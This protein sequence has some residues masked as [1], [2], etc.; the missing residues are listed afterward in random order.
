MRPP[1]PV[2]VALGRM[3]YLSSGRG[4]QTNHIRGHA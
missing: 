4:V 2:A 3:R 1:L